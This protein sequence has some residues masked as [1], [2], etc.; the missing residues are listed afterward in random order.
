VNDYTHNRTLNDSESAIKNLINFKNFFSKTQDEGEDENLKSIS[1]KPSARLH[2]RPKSSYL[3]HHQLE[4]DIST[5]RL[6]VD[7]HHMSSDDLEHVVNV[8]DL[9]DENNQQLDDEQM[10]D[11]IKI[12]L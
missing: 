9:L 12:P 6:D 10:Q 5:E 8:K 11:T 7:N 1:L 3:V 2:I 4:K